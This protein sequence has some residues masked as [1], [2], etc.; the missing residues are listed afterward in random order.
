MCLQFCALYCW[1]VLKIEGAGNLLIG[2]VILLLIAAV[3]LMVTADFKAPPP[4]RGLPA[5]LRY[6]MAWLFLGTLVWFGHGWLAGAYGASMSITFVTLGAW[7]AVAR[8]ISRRCS[9]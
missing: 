9:A 6:S 3:L 7:R 4:P 8:L 5:W 1:K 2:W